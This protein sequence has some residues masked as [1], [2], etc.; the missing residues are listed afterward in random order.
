M[1]KGIKISCSHKSN[2]SSITVCSECFY[3]VEPQDKYCFQC[4]C[5][6]SPTPFGAR[7]GGF[8]WIAGRRKD[9][10]EE[11]KTGWEDEDET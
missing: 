11:D 8:E 4:G 9:Y 1:K 5:L 6:F 7:N 10:Q 3:Q 2:M